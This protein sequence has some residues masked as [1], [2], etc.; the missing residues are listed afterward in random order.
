M[1]RI[2][3]LLGF[4]GAIWIL[5]ASISDA[6]LCAERPPLAEDIEQLH[7]LFVGEVVSIEAVYTNLEI[8]AEK[9]RRLWRVLTE[10]EDYMFPYELYRARV[11]FNVVSAFKGIKGTIDVEVDTCGG[12][13]GYPFEEGRAY[14]V[15]AYVD[16]INP[17]VLVTSGCDR[18]M[19]VEYADELLVQILDITANPGS[20]YQSTSQHGHSPN[21]SFQ[22]DPDPRERGS[23]PLNSNRTPRLSSWLGDTWSSA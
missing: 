6:C 9:T 5:G 11:S 2:I 13:C 12:C 7:S 16:P 18:T 17:S 15:F 22:A 1:K 19:D 23:G 4:F 3:I 10:D 20:E 14:L 8:L 21:K